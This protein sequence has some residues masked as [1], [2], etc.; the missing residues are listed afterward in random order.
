MYRKR[1]LSYTPTGFIATLV[2]ARFIKL[3]SV[4]QLILSEYAKPLST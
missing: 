3:W 2:P 1:T 4:I